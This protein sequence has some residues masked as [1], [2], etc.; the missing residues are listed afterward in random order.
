MV[1]NISVAVAAAA[2]VILVIY[3][4]VVLHNVVKTLKITQPLIK[5]IKEK[6][7]SL[8]FIFEPLS[9]LKEAKADP[10]HYNSEKISAIVNFATD[11]LV[12]FNKFRK[13]KGK[14]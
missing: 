1:I 11:T 5:D 9:R 12:L 2:F 8:N 4:L 13:K 6:S 7:D 3:L 10:K 14:K